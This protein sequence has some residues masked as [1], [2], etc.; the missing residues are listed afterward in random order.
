MNLLFVL[1]NLLLLAG[2]SLALKKQPWS[3]ML[4][5]WFYPALLLKML[6]GILL[7]LLYQHYY[8]SGDTLTYFNGAQ[9]LTTYFHENPEGYFK[10]L[11]LNEFE[12]EGLQESLPF[13]RFAFFSNS[14]FLIKIISLLNLLTGSSYYLISLW[15]SLF[16]FW[17]AARLAATLATH[18]PG[19]SAAAI[20]AFLF[21]PS[22]VFWSSGLLKDSVMMGSMCWVVA[23]AVARAHGQPLR[24]PELLLVLPMLYLFV[25]IK[26]FL[27]AVLLPVLLVYYLLRKLSRNVAVLADVKVQAG[28]LV[29]LV[30]L[31]GIVAWQLFDRLMPNYLLRQVVYSHNKLLE[32]SLHGPHINYG[33]LEPTLGNI[34]RN[35]PE[36]LFSAVYRPFI[37]ES[38]QPLYLLTGLE[39]L[40]LLVLTV[41]LLA[42][43]LLKK[44]RLKIP[45][46]YIG[47]VLYIVVAGVLIGLSTPNFGSLS[48]YRIAFLPFLVYLLLQSYYVQTLFRQLRTRLF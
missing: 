11:L 15:F 16:S 19:T 33:Q 29:T 1:L 20:V 42:S 41:L 2:L 37:G 35:A 46:L 12:T 4:G 8:G 17:G 21:F 3:E 9:R 47:F 26:L 45:L 27:A 10:I 48:R 5:R 7:G 40:V 6:A 23:F 28:V 24:L 34:I 14:F 31:A 39:N 13:A 36:A 38:W 25:R 30:S 44:Q 32:Q 18:F 22:V 43:W